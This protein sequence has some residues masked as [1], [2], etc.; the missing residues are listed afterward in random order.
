MN[1]PRQK[2]KNNLSIHFLLKIIINFAAVRA[3]GITILRSGQL[4]M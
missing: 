2:I 4:N 3:E 1:E